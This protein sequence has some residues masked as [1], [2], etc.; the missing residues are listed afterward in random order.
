MTATSVTRHRMPAEFARELA[1]ER[2]ARQQAEQERDE[3]IAARQEAEAED[4]LLKVA[5]VQEVQE[6]A[7]GRRRGKTGT[8]EERLDRSRR[9]PIPCGRMTQGR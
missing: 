8:T 3:A 2:A 5:A 7:V 6:S 1:A 4:R 9:F